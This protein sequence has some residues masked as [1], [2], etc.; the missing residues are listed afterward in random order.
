MLRET[1]PTPRSFNAWLLVTD[2]QLLFK[3]TGNP[4]KAPPLQKALFLDAEFGKASLNR[5]LIET[6][7]DLLW[8]LSFSMR[9]DQE[10]RRALLT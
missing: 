3:T 8:Y 9:L 5:F 4:S 2:C 6:F 7:N 10:V 1:L